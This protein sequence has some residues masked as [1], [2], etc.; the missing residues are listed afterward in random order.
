MSKDYYTI[1]GVDRDATPE[2]IKKAYR[3][4]A[5]KVHPDVAPDDAEAAEKFKELSEAYEVLSDPN[6]RAIFDRGGDPMSGAGGAGFSGFGGG[7]AG[8]FDFTNLVDAMFGQAGG[9]GPRSRV[10]QGQ[11]ALVRLSLDLHE[12]V[13]GATKPVKVATAVVCPKC[14]GKGGE[15]GSEP[16]TCSTCSGNGEITQIQRSFLGDI[17]TSQACPTCRGYGTII[18]RPCSECSGEGRVRTTRTL[19][20]K[21]PAGVS[22]GIRIHLESQGEVGPGGGPAGDLYVELSVNEHESFRRDGDNLEMVVK[23]PMTAA[24]LGTTIDLTTLEAEWEK[25]D[26]EDRSVSVEVP[27]GTQSGTRIGLKGRGVPRLRGGGR[28]ELGV[29]LLVQTPTKLDD[30]QRE[31]LRQLADA[32]DETRIEAVAAKPGKGGMFGKLSEWFS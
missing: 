25:S 19:Q 18:P 21:I 9:R 5:M 31:L 26:V 7:F 6:K 17:R 20:V 29:T 23:L 1:L 11:D 4:R 8:G 28:G 22:T 12:A 16:V 2:S 32:R 15:P 14:T 30:Q 3:R 24:A 13:F 27:A 10:R